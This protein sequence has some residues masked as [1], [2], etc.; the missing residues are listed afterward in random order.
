MTN[1]NKPALPESVQRLLGAGD[2]VESRDLYAWLN[3]AL[4][5][6]A[7]GQAVPSLYVWWSDD[8][9]RIRAFSRGGAQ[10]KRLREQIG[11]EPDVFV[12][13]AAAQ[14]AEPSDG[15]IVALKILRESYNPG[16]GPVSALRAAALDAAIAALS[17]YGAQPA[18]DHS[19]LLRR[20][21]D[22]GTGQRLARHLVADTQA[23]LA[24]Q[25]AASAE[26][27][28]AAAESLMAAYRAKYRRGIGLIKLNAPL[29]DEFKALSTALHVTPVAP[30]T[31]QAPQPVYLGA[32]IAD[33]LDSMADDQ[34]AGSQAQSDLFAAATVWRKHVAG[35]GAQ[36]P[37]DE[38]AEFEA[39][40]RTQSETWLIVGGL[41]W[42]PGT[43]DYASARTN[44]AWAA[45]Q[46]RAAQAPASFQARVQPWMMECFGAEISADRE[47]RNH[48]FL[49]EALEL[50]QACGCTATEAHQLVDYVF[51]RPVG[52]PAQETGGVMVTLAAL[53]LANGLDMYEAGERELARIS[54]PE[55]V[56][57]IRAKQAAKP[58]HSP[59]PQAPAAAGDALTQAAR[60]VLAERQHQVEIGYDAAHDDEHVNDEIAALATLYM[61]PPAARQWPATETGYG[62]TWGRAIVPEGWHAEHNQPRRKELVMAVAMGLAEIERLDRAAMSTGREVQP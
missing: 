27:V 12:S 37:Q 46:V 29:L 3:D 26:P 44:A 9:E 38:R 35:P 31:A 61:M 62:D 11:R 56:A 20:W 6:Q 39:W 59:L 22:F 54:V 52:E 34:P 58:R 10:V 50:V 60:D 40:A 4:Q 5:A 42:S 45:W 15:H 55:T 47:E 19:N 17:R 28:R 18:A 2:C 14:K 8:G 41:T 57:K 24:A 33:R 23:V 53:C 43:N 25:P 21:L 30:V 1:E 32:T 16:H 13:P 48:R 36:A 49:E 7:S 51:G